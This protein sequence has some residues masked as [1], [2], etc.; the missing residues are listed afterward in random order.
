MM[1][2][3]KEIDQEQKGLINWELIDKK[4]AVVIP[5]GYLF[6]DEISF[7]ILHKVQLTQTQSSDSTQ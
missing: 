5:K 1:E 4:V 6:A 2:I 7:R 3:L